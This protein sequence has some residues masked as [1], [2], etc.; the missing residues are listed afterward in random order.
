MKTTAHNAL[1]LLMQDHKMVKTMFKEFQG[2]SDKSKSTKKRLADKICHEL[3]VHTTI[4]EEIF[5]PAV[6]KAIKDKAMMDEALVEH[7]SAKQLISQ[8]VQMDASEDFFDAKVLVLSEQIEH[9]VKEEEGEMFPKVRKTKL[10]L[11]ALG[12]QM[13]ERKQELELVDT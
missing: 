3:T 12:M 2:L 11:H 9:H 7:A 13:A 1:N 4:E 10:D 5:Y 6:S 8:I